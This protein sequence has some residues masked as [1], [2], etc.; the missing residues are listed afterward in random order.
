MIKGSRTRASPVRFQR[1]TG[2]GADRFAQG[3]RNSTCAPRRRYTCG[4]RG[5][6]VRGA[7]PAEDPHPEEMGPTPDGL[8]PHPQSLRPPRSRFPRGAKRGH[9]SPATTPDAVSVRSRRVLAL[10]PLGSGQ[11]YP[12]G[13]EQQQQPQQQHKKPPPKINNPQRHQNREA[14]KPRRQ[15]GRAPNT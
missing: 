1:S 13:L 9:F 14:N 10:S 5:P 4:L 8:R 3:P 2:V 11:A 15:R 7:H 12:R 6:S